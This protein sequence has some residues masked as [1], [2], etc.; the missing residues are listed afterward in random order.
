MSAWRRGD[1][2]RVSEGRLDPKA[3]SKQARRKRED[4]KDNAWR[5]H[6]GISDGS[7]QA[8]PDRCRAKTVTARRFDGIG[9]PPI[10]KTN[11]MSDT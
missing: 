2:N 6:D 3:E 9:S 8:L 11:E 1:D 7:P 4:I 5:R 10:E